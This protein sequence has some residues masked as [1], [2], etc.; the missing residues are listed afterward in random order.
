MD[1]LRR[2]D[3]AKEPSWDE[4]ISEA[5]ERIVNNFGTADSLFLSPSAVE[6]MSKE[7]NGLSDVLS[8]DSD[9]ESN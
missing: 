7:F 9:S 2:L 8:K 3:I 6:E 1:T 5:I 4:V